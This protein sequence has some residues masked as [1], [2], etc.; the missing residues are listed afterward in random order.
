[1]EATQQKNK[2]DCDKSVPVEPTTREGDEIYL[3]RPHHAAFAS[4][5]AV[6]LA[7]MEYNKIMR[8]T[9]RSEKMTKVQ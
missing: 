7:G 3:N 1:M 5:A 4:D 2:A 8:C 9:R 6:E